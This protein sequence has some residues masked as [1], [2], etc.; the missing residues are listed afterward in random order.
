MKL[1]RMKRTS[2][3]GLGTLGLLAIV[4]LV[5]VS[6]SAAS[7]CS[8][9]NGKIAAGAGDGLALIGKGGGVRWLL[10]SSRS[11]SATFQPSFSCSGKAIVYVGDDETTCPPI[12]IVNPLTGKRRFFPYPTFR[13]T[14]FPTGGCGFAP[15]FLR[16]GRLLFG[17][18]GPASKDGTYVADGDGRHRHRLFDRFVCASTADAR[19]FLE[20]CGRSLILLN[21]QGQRVRTITPRPPRAHVHY[22]VANFSPD[23][24]WIVYGR[25]I[26]TAAGGSYDY[27]DVFVVRRDGTHRRRL[28]RGGH[29]FE[30]SFSPD[31]RWVAFVRGSEGFGR[32][33]V[34]LPLA[35]PGRARV[36]VKADSPL[37]NPAWGVG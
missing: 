21:R 31:G 7:T 6:A 37:R 27:S 3:I 25:A 26:D 35:H 20:G 13:T 34:A 29:S 36:L 9:Q 17:V 18:R 8:G 11:S 24:R 14:A 4:L 1:K 2:A 5:P 23:G 16:D 10:T 28:T 22:L 15:S 33:I 19:W 30:P 32:Q 12:E